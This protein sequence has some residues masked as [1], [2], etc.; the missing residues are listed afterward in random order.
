[1]NTILE[2][3]NAMNKTKQDRKGERTVYLTL[4]GPALAMASRIIP[5][6]ILK[7]H[8]TFKINGVQGFNNS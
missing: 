7:V 8:P 1:M 6:I 3:R 4:Q 5:P 2:N